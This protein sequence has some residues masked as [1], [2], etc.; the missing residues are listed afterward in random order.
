M[1]NKSKNIYQRI[2][3]VMKAVDYIQKE[4]KRVN[5]QYTFVSHDAVTAKL[6][7]K[8]VEHGIV[9]PVSVK[10]YKQD[11]NRTEVLINVRFVNV[12]EPPDFIEVDAFGYGIDPQDKGPGKAISYAFKY[13]LLKTFC[14]ETGDDPEKDNVNHKPSNVTSIG[15]GNY[16]VTAGQ[17]KGRSIEEVANELGLDAIKGKIAYFKS[18]A[19]KSGKPN[20]GWVLDFIKHATDYILSVEAP[21]YIGEWQG[22]P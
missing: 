13:A 20:N 19:K 5:N 9:T 14:L 1:E 8:F 15:G 18:D 11:G 21:G 3:E 16:K 4:D 7:D 12:D 2:A 10:S 17:W 6:R 22:H